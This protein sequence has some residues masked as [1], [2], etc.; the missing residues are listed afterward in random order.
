[1]DGSQIRRNKPCWHLRENIGKSAIN[2]AFLLYGFIY[3]TLQKYFKKKPYHPDLVK[4]FNDIF[5]KTALGQCEDTKN[6]M[7]IHSSF[8][9]S[10][11]SKIV[12]Y[13]TSYYTFYLPVTC[14]MIMVSC[15]KYCKKSSKS[16]GKLLHLVKTFQLSLIF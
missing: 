14:A 4:L 12:K 8:S 6:S 1:M 5:F 13:K 16:S 10:V 7:E 11:Y 3:Q 2:D 15:R 9:M